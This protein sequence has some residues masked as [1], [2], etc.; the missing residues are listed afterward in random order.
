MTGRLVGL[1][2][3]QRSRDQFF[4][5]P[6][7]DRLHYS[8]E[9]N[10]IES[11]QPNPDD[12]R[13]GR[14]PEREHRMKVCVQRDDDTSVDPGALQDVA[15]GRGCHAKFSHMATRHSRITQNAGGI[16]GQPL[17]EKE[18]RHPTSHQAT[19]VSTALSSKLAAANAK[20]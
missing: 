16:A 18:A 10:P 15:V 9:R 6:V 8:R 19:E 7:Q 5:I 11:L 17:V 3:N 13:L 2:R 4:F 20:A 1:Y 14:P 12:R